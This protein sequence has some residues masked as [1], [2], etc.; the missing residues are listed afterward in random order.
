MDTN[1]YKYIYVKE[2]R[3]LK[4]KETLE[5]KYFLSTESAKKNSNQIGLI[6]Y[7]DKDQLIKVEPLESSYRYL[8][9]SGRYF[10]EANS[11]AQTTL[12][13]NNFIRGINDYLEGIGWKGEEYTNADFLTGEA[14]IE[15]QEG[16]FTLKSLANLKKE[17]AILLIGVVFLILYYLHVSTKEVGIYKLHGFRSAYIWWRLIGRKIIT[18]FLISL[19]VVFFI[20]Y[21]QAPS[22][23]FLSIAYQNLILT[24]MI[25]IFFSFI[26][27]IYINTFKIS[28][29]IKDKRETAVII[30]LNLCIKIGCIIILASLGTQIMHEKQEM[31]RMQLQYLSQH[32]RMEDKDWQGIANDYGI[33]QAYTGHTQAYTLG[34]YESE[35]SKSDKLLFYLY[36]NFN[37]LGSLYVDAGNY[38]EETIFINRN[39]TGILSITVNPNFLNKYPIFDINGDQV[40]IT[41]KTED[42]IFLVPDK[43]RDRENDIQEYF[44]E[45]KYRDFYLSPD[46]GQ[47]I[48]IVWLQNNQE[49]FSMN[50]EVFPAEDNV[51]LDPIIQVKTLNNYLFTYRGGIKG[52]ALRDPLK[53]K[54]QNGSISDT[55]RILEDALKEN[56]LDDRIKITSF[57]Q[58]IKNEVEYARKEITKLLNQFFATLL[59]FSFIAIQSA[60]IYFNK[61]QKLF[62]IKRLLGVGF[63]R[64]YL[65]YLYWIL[66]S[67]SSVVLLCYGINV[68]KIYAFLEPYFYL[69][70]SILL[71]IELILAS[72]FILLIENKKSR[73]VIKGGA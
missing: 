38:E 53:L 36:P 51:I 62:S 11:D 7:F 35:L 66:I 16:F 42:W 34:E 1:F 61:N 8:P 40:S 27:S 70:L 43:Y 32:E 14:S 59:V 10:L 9:T 52:R 18:I 30:S 64:T 12:F 69:C 6:D 3:E 33:V 28:D 26:G 44:N 25:L 31:K 54:L 45:K 55:N 56:K 41:E 4:S 24:F 60:I 37:S 57:N 15:P 50:P 13:M 72:L 5:E 23:Y 21:A 68:L 65:P 63:I 46:V 29:S 58:F 49:I 19:L 17:Q 67:Y 71:C 47:E 20:S 73:E 2:G 22:I 39:H 48:K